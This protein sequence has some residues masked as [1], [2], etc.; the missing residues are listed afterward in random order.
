M[1]T[2]PETRTFSKTLAQAGL[3]FRS[4]TALVGDV[5]RKAGLTRAARSAPLAL[6]FVTAATLT[7]EAKR[8]ALVVGNA[9]YD[10]VYALKNATNDAQDLAAALE[11]LDF[12]VTLLTDATEADFWS[13]LDTFAASAAEAESA[14]F[15]FSGHAFQLGGANYLVPKDATLASKEAIENETWR[16]DEIV[17]R[18]SAKNRQTLIFLD[19]CRNN[20][21]PESLRGGAEGLAQMEKGSG[22]FVA[23]ATQPN[24][25]TSDGAGEN[26]PFTQALLNHIEEPGISVSDLMIRVRNDVES[27]TFGRQTPWDQSSLRAQFYFNPQV[28]QTAELTDADY[29][30]IAALDPETRK[31][32]LA[33][34]GNSGTNIVIEDVEEEVEEIVEAVAIVD[35][36]DVPDENTPT[37]TPGKATGDTVVASNEADTATGAD[38]AVVV[39]G[40][41]QAPERVAAGGETETADPTGD[42]TTVVASNEAQRTEGTVGAERVTGTEVAGAERVTGSEVTGTEVAGAERVTGTE[43]TGAESTGTDVAAAVPADPNGSRTKVIGPDG[44]EREAVILAGLAPT[45]SLEPST[46]EPRSRVVGQEIER[47]SEEARAAGV[48]PEAPKLTGKD[49]AMAVQTELSR[50]GC[51]RMAIDGDWGKGSRV[52]LFRYYAARA[53]ATDQLEPTNSLLRRLEADDE[54]ACKAV[55]QVASKKAS[56]AITQV[57]KAAATKRQAAPTKAAASS[58]SKKRIQ[59][60]TTTVRTKSGGTKKTVTKKLRAGVF[61]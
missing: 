38:S 36:V 11:R 25:V 56:Q 27:E 54:V 16:L 60:N 47:D 55:Q 45:R 5:A 24:N 30:L 33:A 17:K 28:E 51:Y 10:N 48:A 57:R 59:G 19:A 15:F 18:L 2:A 42:A 61:R 14:M 50:L 1:A 34:L 13:R 41:D 40:G 9:D 20:P 32:L 7:A 21:L 12:E 49:L 44:E 52:S 3:G 26:S 31:R 23:F 6:V 43:V 22:T 29:E 4:A 53:I 58:S 39:I 8:V 35:I 37:E 46:A